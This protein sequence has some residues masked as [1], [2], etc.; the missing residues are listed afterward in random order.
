MSVSSWPWCKSQRVISVCSC[1]SALWLWLCCADRAQQRD[2]WR[3]PDCQSRLWLCCDAWHFD[4]RPGVRYVASLGVGWISL[5]RTCDTCVGLHGC[6]FPMWH[7]SHVETIVPWLI[8]CT[9]VLSI[10]VHKLLS[11]C[12]WT[13]EPSCHFRHVLLGPRALDQATSL[14]PGP[15]TWSFPRSWHSLWALPW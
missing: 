15:D 10:K 1:L 9:Q 14:C 12:R 3:F 6:T 13:P 4:R 2:P 8:S 5:V 7:F 11:F